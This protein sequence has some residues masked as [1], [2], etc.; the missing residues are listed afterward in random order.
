[1]ASIVPVFPAGTYRHYMIEGPLADSTI[2]PPP[3]PA[4][5]FNERF[6]AARHEEGCYGM[7]F[8]M[9][10]L[11]CRGL[12]NDDVG[13]ARGTVSQ[14]TRPGA[15]VSKPA[16]SSK[17]NVGGAI[18]ERLKYFVNLQWDSKGAPASVGLRNQL[19]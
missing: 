15:G 11:V 17:K 2:A 3:K 5:F 9:H 13:V 7:H 14:E 12:S 10:F 18:V 16:I 19:N 8:S 4:F 1:M 6:M